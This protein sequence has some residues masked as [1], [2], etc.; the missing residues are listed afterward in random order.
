MLLQTGS[1]LN[2][3]HPKA[4]PDLYSLPR[5]SLLLIFIFLFL[6]CWY[7]ASETDVTEVLDE[8]TTYPDSLGLVGSTGITF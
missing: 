6:T 3:N 1:P 8:V 7:Q 4:L 5:C 2:L